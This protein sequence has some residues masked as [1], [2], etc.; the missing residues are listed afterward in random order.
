MK[1]NPKSSF[2]VVEFFWRGF[3][4]THLPFYPSKHG[5][6]LASVVDVSIGMFALIKYT[7]WL[8]LNVDALTVRV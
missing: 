3:N 1:K 4:Y 5:I 6:V 7:N 2:L 8:T